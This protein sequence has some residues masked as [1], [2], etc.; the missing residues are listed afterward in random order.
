MRVKLYLNFNTTVRK[1]WSEDIPSNI[2]KA[3]GNWPTVLEA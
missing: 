1:I 2:V 3:D